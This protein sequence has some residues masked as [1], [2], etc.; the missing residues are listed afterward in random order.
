MVRSV[1]LILFLIFNS[2]LI[3]RPKII[4]NKILTKNGNKKQMKKQTFRNWF[5][6]WKI[7]K[8][9][10]NLKQKKLDQGFNEMNWKSWG[11]AIRKNKLKNKNIFFFFINLSKSVNLWILLALCNV[12]CKQNVYCDLRKIVF[13]LE[14][15][16]REIKNI[17]RIQLKQDFSKKCESNR[18]SK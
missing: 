7:V 3:F 4:E 1:S 17:I 16:I 12:I 5:Q 11:F 15:S 2:F 14:N 13:G 6:L 9:C 10:V 8:I 18:R